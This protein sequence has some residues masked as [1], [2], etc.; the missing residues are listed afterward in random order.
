MGVRPNSTALSEMVVSHFSENTPV[1]SIGLWYCPVCNICRT[2]ARLVK[3]SGQCIERLSWRLGVNGH[4]NMYSGMC[5][6]MKLSKVV[7]TLWKRD[8]N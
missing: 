2:Y 8:D 3:K 6:F 7:V 1:E 4:H 5:L